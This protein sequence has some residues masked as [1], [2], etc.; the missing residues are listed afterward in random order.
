MHCLVA[1]LSRHHRRIARL[2][3]LETSTLALLCRPANCGRHERQ[4]E[5]FMHC[6][7]VSRRFHLWTLIILDRSE[8]P[9]L[10][11]IILDETTGAPP[12]YAAG[13]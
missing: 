2:C 5:V 12:A 10:V 4:S 1:A 9:S 11:K 8:M 13:S 6:A 3:L 7:K